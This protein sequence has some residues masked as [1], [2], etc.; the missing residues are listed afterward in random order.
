MP[1]LPFRGYRVSC[2]VSISEHAAM[3][4]WLRPWFWRDTERQDCV[5]VNHGCS[6]APPV[7]CSNPVP[8]PHTSSPRDHHSVAYT[9]IRQRVIRAVAI[10]TTRRA[11]TPR[12][13]SAGKVI[14][15]NWRVIACNIRREGRIIPCNW[16]VIPCNIRR[17]ERRQEGE[18]LVRD[19]D[20]G[21]HG[22]A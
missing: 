22:R 16:R 14:P 20:R 7:W 18:Y 3:L 10:Y 12:R 15:C 2:A 21:V 6:P 1:P 9:A 11:R 4:L 19:G 5:P 13:P 17:P 8:A